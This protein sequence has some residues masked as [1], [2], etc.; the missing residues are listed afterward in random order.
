[1]DKIEK[2][3]GLMPEQELATYRKAALGNTIGYGKRVALLNVD[4]HNMFVDPKY[5]FCGA[6]MP[7]LIDALVT[8]TD[9]FR[10]L[11]LPIYYVRR[12]D[13]RHPV[14]RGVRNLKM[15]NADDAQ[16]TC[17]PKA[18]EWPAAYAPEEN[19]VIVYKNKPSAFFR[20]PLEAWLRYDGVD[21]LV[22]CGISTSGCVRAA[23][24]DAFSENFRVIVP[25]EACGDR[26]ETAHRM[27][28]FD[29]DM[30]YAD[31][32][33]LEKVVED[34]SRHFSRNRAVAE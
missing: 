15:S 16:Y 14:K 32:E 5:A 12:D 26:S 18:D 33:P 24:C 30:K 19:D 7:E 21:T 11:G 28:L 34:L 2:W 3:Q 4:T 23:V 27:N 1:M 17:D 20:T 8:I 10:G 9:A 31:V 29:M 13:W 6:E 22:I 25:A